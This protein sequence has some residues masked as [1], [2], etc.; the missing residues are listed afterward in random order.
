MTLPDFAK[1]LVSLGYPVFYDHFTSTQTLP[2]VVYMNP[3]DNTFG[4]D[5]KVV[6]KTKNINVEVYTSKKDLALEA[7]I[8]KLFDDNELYYDD[9][10]EVYIV[11]EK[12]YKRTY[13]LTI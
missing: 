4:A 7:K 12:V 5:N 10:D 9:P 8:E 2:F 13:Y 1:L 3:N 6:H 11:S